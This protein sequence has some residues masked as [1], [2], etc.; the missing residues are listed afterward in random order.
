MS[1]RCLSSLLL[2]AGVALVGVARADA[3]IDEIRAVNPEGLVR[4]HNARGE[5]TVRGWDRDEVQVTGDA[6]DMA[7]GV[8]FEVK[9][10]Q[11]LI[12][13]G[14]PRRNHWGDGSDLEVWMP[15]ASGLVVDA[16]SADVD[17]E[18]IAGAM[19]I[20]TVGGDVE[21]ADIAGQTR[22]RTVSG[23]VD[24]SGGSGE[25][26]VASTSGD[27]EI[28]ADAGTVVVDT[29]TGDIEVELGAFDSLRAQS[30]EGALEVEGQLNPNGNLQAK[31]VMSPI[32]VRLEEPV[33]A[34]IRAT[35]RVQGEI[36]N[37]LSDDRPERA[38]AGLSLRATVGDGSGTIVLGTIKGGIEIE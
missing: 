12:H 32:E 35:T 38:G 7:D 17:V 23:D 2:I 25:L 18:G 13:V 21:V 30:V 15:A 31:T 33:H 14:V 26:Y 1:A 24:V 28:E 6:D 22:I 37:R 34:E 10:G 16:V 11:T 9:D 27:L 29:M 5:L 8:R 19:H 36:R 4:I 20:R 3:A